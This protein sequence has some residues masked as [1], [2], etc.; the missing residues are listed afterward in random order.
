M[1]VPRAEHLAGKRQHLLAQLERLVPAS[2]AEVGIRQA[3][4][5]PERVGVLRAEHLAGKRQHLLLQLERLVPAAGDGVGKRQVLHRLER[6]GMLWAEHLAAQRQHLLAQLERLVPAVGVGVGN[7]QFVHC[8]ER[9]GVLR[10]VGGQVVVPHLFLQGEGLPREAEGKIGIAQRGLQRG[11]AVGLGGEVGVQFLR[12]FVEGLG[13]GDGAAVALRVRALEDLAEERRDGLRVL[14]RLLL[15]V[16]LGGDFL[17]RGGGLFLGIDRPHCQPQAH[18]CRGDQHG[19]DACGHAQRGFVPP[20]IFLELV[21]RT[22]WS[23][24]HRFVGE[25]SFDVGGET[26]G[27]LVAAGAVF[28]DGLHHDP[29]EVGLD[30]PAQLLRLDVPGLGEQRPLFAHDGAEAR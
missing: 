1:G 20:G 9:V 22:R 28:L 7:R 30:H 13:D 26:V 4:Y 6:V 25:E 10:A 19:G 16:A 27:R 8:A 21:A 17:E 14:A 11:A 2:G 5:R 29:V 3:D 18:D 15:G 12:R 23:R 24:A